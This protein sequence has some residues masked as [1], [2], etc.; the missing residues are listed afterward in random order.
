MRRALLCLLVGLLGCVST[1]SA[2][3]REQ[4]VRGDKTKYEATGFW[5]YNDL[6]KGFAEAK[7]SG[8]P[9]LVVLRCLP[10]EHCVKLDDELVETDATLRPLLEK[11]VRVRVIS[12]NGLD[13]S[14]FQFDTD[15]S[16]AVF[17]LNGD[18]T[19]YGRYG[20]RSDQTLYADDVSIEGLAKALDGALSLHQDYPK[21]KDE[22]A[23][24][25]GPAPAFSSPEK[26][27]KLQGKYG[28]AINYEA[29]LIQSCIHC[30][31]IG[32]AVKQHARE[33]GGALPEQVLFPYPHPKALGLILNPR[34]R[35][36][37]VRVEADSLADQAGFRA[38]DEIQKLG[39]QTP[40]SIADVQWVLHH[41][42]ASG[43]TVAAT[44]L[45]D[46]RSVPVELKLP[47]EW[48]QLDDIAWRASSWELRRM[49][50]GGLF[51]KK[52]PAEVRAEMKL[53]SDKLVLRAQHVGQYAPHNGA[54]EAGLKVGDVLVSFDGKDDFL[55]E[56]DL[57]EYALNHVKPGSSVPVVVRRE[58]KNLE[59]TLKIPK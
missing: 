48:K 45:R 26:Y 36:K 35:A 19:I 23:L 11:F 4:K 55:R 37:V 52:M 1:L 16:Y 25:R 8:K 38:G 18:G 54:K 30:H 31:Q 24:K 43:G 7:A 34:E 3:T 42:P 51:L 33:R 49:A 57:L 58:G 22:L 17:M 5:I 2:Q 39:G 53:P 13:L 9:M 27:P 20:T 29:N 44:V 32:D 56:T 50:L 40:L 15:Q 14:L 21:N 12:A 46:G 59:L 6:T 28:S 41:T 10:C 47:A